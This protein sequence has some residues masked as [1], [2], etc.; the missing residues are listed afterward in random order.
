MKNNDFSL[1]WIV[2]SHSASRDGHWSGLG[3]SDK[4]FPAGP[5]TT[6]KVYDRLH[7]Y[8]TPLSSIGI[9]NTKSPFIDYMLIYVL[10]HVPPRLLKYTLTRL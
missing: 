7:N 3:N 1:D 9:I 6:E 5:S 10:I 4:N 8:H 2:K